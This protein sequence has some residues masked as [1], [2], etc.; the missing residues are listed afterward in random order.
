MR[1]KDYEQTPPAGT[2]RIALLGASHVFGSGVKDDETFETIMEN[3]L[4][5]EYSIDSNTTYEVLN[6]GRQ[7]RTALHQI[8]ILENKI[9]DF[10]P[11]TVVYVTHPKDPRRLV[12]VLAR[13][14]HQGH[15][16]PYP[17]V[18]E[19]LEKAGISRDMKRFSIERALMPYKY[20]LVEWAYSRITEICRQNGITPV[21]VLL[22]MTYERLEQSDIEEHLATA[23]AAGFTTISLKDVYNSAAPDELVIAPWDDHPNVLGHR[24]IAEYLYDAMLEKT[25][26]I[27]SKQVSAET[28]DPR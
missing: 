12:Q 11:D 28:A 24:L 3:R 1:D 18:E 19:I 6:F 2:H 17:R 16:I 5:S 7:G 27:P 15:A 26:I 13:Q 14:V 22:P 21:W 10:Q 23:E 8:M 25:G 20:E 9:L 4:N